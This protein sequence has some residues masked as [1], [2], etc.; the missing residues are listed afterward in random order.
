MLGMMFGASDFEHL[1]Q[2]PTKGPCAQIVVTLAPK[3]VCMYIY[4]YI[5]R[6]YISAKVYTTWVHAPFGENC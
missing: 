1:P 2:D 4:I 5:Y 6:D 3:Y